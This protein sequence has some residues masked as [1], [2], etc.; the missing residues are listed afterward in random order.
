MI[1]QMYCP[2]CGE[3]FTISQCQKA[4]LDIGSRIRSARKRLGMTQP[5]LA[6]MLENPR[7][8]NF[9][10]DIEFGRVVPSLDV[11]ANIAGVLGVDADYLLGELPRRQP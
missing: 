11:L 6:W 9:I 5:Q 10:H 7:G 3:P 1:E 2:H 4:S 8:Y